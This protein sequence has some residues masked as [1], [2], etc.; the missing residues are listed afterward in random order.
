M[1]FTRLLLADK[2]VEWILFEWAIRK[3]E[4]D[5]KF[6]RK[7]CSVSIVRI[8]YPLNRSLLR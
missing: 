4:T 2:N 8:Y 5:K 3:S 6:A 7:R 1:R